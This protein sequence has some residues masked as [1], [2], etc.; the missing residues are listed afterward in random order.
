[1]IIRKLFEFE[2]AH[3]VRFCSSKRCKSSIH[4]HSYKVEVL[5]ESKYLDNAGMVYDFGLLKTYIR[6]IIDSFDHAITLFNQDDQS[7][8]HEMKKYSQR[9]ITLPVN[10]SAENFCR[11]FFILIDAL[12]KQTKMVNGEQG[13][14][15]QSI[16]VHETR[17][18]YAQAFKDD[19]YS[20]ILPK[21]SLNDIE[22]S[23]AIKAEWNDIDFYDKLKNSYIFTNPKEI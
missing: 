21:I 3:I 11:V 5:L 1:M 22:F 6:Q 23:P 20:D 2:N 14:N 19:A 13:V 7:Y 15:L 9:W 4:G 18:G 8:L 16:I 17:T 12:L 10:V